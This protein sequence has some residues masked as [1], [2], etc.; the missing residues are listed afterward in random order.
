MLNPC[1]C[2][3]R[4]TPRNSPY[5]TSYNAIYSKYGVNMILQRIP[6]VVDTC[7][8]LRYMPAC[9]YTNENNHSHAFLANGCSFVVDISSRPDE[10]PVMSYRPLFLFH[11]VLQCPK[12][13]I[14]CLLSLTHFHDTSLMYRQQQSVHIIEGFQ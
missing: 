7:A 5:R 14:G 9:T 8:C 3:E 10:L 13:N 6:E 1:E 2:K 12:E 11:S 4:F